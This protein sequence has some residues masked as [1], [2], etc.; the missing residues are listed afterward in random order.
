MLPVF[1]LN[2]QCQM[3]S[4]CNC[5][6]KP[7]EY[8]RGAGALIFLSAHSIAHAYYSTINSRKNLTSRIKCRD[9]E[10]EK[11]THRDP[12]IIGT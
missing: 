7:N 1:R 6:A 8:M 5:I 10:E 9:R 4:R 11:K 2:S 12:N 3:T